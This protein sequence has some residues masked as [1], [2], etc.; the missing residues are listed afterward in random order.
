LAEQ[1]IFLK[2]FGLEGSQDYIQAKAKQHNL[3]PLYGTY[4]FH[5]QYVQTFAELGVIGFLILV[6]MLF[7][8]LKNAFKYKDFLHITFAI[9]MIMLFLVGIVFL[10]DKEELFFLIVLYCLFNSTSIQETEKK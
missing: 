1:P 2:G 10:A 4:N 8:N 7:I 9:T 6:F 5:N 3:N